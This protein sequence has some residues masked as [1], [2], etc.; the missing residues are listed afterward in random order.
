M[1]KAQATLRVVCIVLAVNVL[2]ALAFGFLPRAFQAIVSEYGYFSLLAT[3]SFTAV[4]SGLSIYGLVLRP[5]VAARRRAEDA[6]CDTVEN[7][8]EGF[9]MFDSEDRLA[10]CNTK[11]RELYS[12]ASDLY[13]YGRTFE[14]ILRSAAARGQY[15]EAEGRI[16]EW[17]AERLETHLNP[18]AAIERQLPDGRWVNIRET[19]TKNGSTLG[20]RSDITDLKR[21]EQQ[22]RESEEQLRQIVESLQEGFVLYDDKDRIVMWNEKWLSVHNNVV[23]VVTPGLSFESLLRTCVARNTYPEAFGREE[24]FIAERIQLHRSPGREMIRQTKDG[25]WFVIREVRTTGG[26]IFALT[27]DITALKKAE[28]MAQQARMQ[29]E[30]ADRSKSEFLANMSHELRTP[31]NAIIGFSDVMEHEAFGPLG[32]AKYQGYAKD[33]K[34]SGEHLLSLISDIL[35]LSKIESGKDELREENVDVVSVVHATIRLVRQG[36]AAKGLCLG[37]NIAADAPMLRADERKLTQILIN[38]LSNAIK[39]TEAD[40]SVT[41]DV[42]CDPILGYVFEV[43]DTGIGISPENIPKAMSQFSQIDSSINRQVDGTGLGL[44]LTKALVELHGGS[45]NLRSEV[46]VG[47]TVTARFPAE[48]ILEKPAVAAASPAA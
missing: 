30:Q 46:G 29:A 4:V 12:I 8:S 42:R 24:A 10:L 6:L 32:S 7:I 38:L 47:T 18:G 25:C 33:I 31:L 37:V 43:S 26:G 28:T 1:S 23:D 41:L 3:A 15:P 44:P 35:D 39:F 11:Y 36:A 22:L 5:L 27:I 20:I 9:L 17:I 34:R 19:R 14:E 40:G 45:L 2:L 16:D 48:R 13:V 21:R